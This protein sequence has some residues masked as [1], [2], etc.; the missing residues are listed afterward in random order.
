MEIQDRAST[1]GGLEVSK[2]KQWFLVG[3]HGTISPFSS[4]YAFYGARKIARKLVFWVVNNCNFYQ[5]NH[6]LA[7]ILLVSGET[8]TSHTFRQNVATI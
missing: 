8:R 4:M 7:P 5:H 1:W 6:S 2:E 3:G